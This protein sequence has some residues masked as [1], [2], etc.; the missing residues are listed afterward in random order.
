MRE[1]LAAQSV[2]PPPLPHRRHRALQPAPTPG[3]R[4]SADGCRLELGEHLLAAGFRGVVGRVGPVLVR[5][6][7][8]GDCPATPCRTAP[9]ANPW[10]KAG[11]IC[12]TPGAPAPRSRPAGCSADPIQLML[13]LIREIAGHERHHRAG[14]NVAAA[15]HLTQIPLPLV[16]PSRSRLGAPTVPAVSTIHRVLQR[17][18]LILR[19]PS[20]APYPSGDASNGSHRMTCGR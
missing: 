16:S 1:A 18:S 11:R 7:Q 12:R 6:R 10:C 19:A 9:T 3:C 4:V 5:Q 14:V 2:T 20:V 13:N 17:N 15:Q 8:L